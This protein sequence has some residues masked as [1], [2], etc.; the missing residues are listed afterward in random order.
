MDVKLA[1]CFTRD[2]LF[3][4]WRKKDWK[5][6]WLQPPTDQPTENPEGDTMIMLYMSTT[7]E[8]GYR[9]PMEDEVNWYDLTHAFDSGAMDIVC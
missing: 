6:V 5:E 2:R 9:E 4:G 8:A 7:G 1:V 3:V